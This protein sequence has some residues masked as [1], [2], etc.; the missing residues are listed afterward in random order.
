MKVSGVVVDKK[1]TTAHFPWIC[2]VISPFLQH[3]S[4]ESEGQDAATRNA[5]P[6]KLRLTPPRSV[7]ASAASSRP[8][9]ENVRIVSELL[10]RRKD[11]SW[12]I[13]TAKRFSHSHHRV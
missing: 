5:R 9:V 3:K 6:V 13:S 10:N 8:A 1:P 12:L 4:T 7:N 2:A 11:L